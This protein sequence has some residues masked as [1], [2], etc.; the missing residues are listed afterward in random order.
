[1]SNKIRNGKTMSLWLE[2]L[3]NV[4]LGD[5][6]EAYRLLN[7]ELPL[8]LRV[9]EVKGRSEWRYTGPVPK[10]VRIFFASLPERDR[11]RAKSRSDDFIDYI[12]DL[13]MAKV[14][15]A[16][17]LAEFAREFQKLTIKEIAERFTGWNGLKLGDENRVKW[18][19][20]HLRSMAAAG[21]EIASVATV[22]ACAG[23]PNEGE[24]YGY[25]ELALVNKWRADLSWKD[26]K[27]QE[28]LDSSYV[29]ITDSGLEEDTNVSDEAFDYGAITAA[30]VVINLSATPSSELTVDLNRIGEKLTED[31]LLLLETFHADKPSD[32]YFPIAW[33]NVW[34]TLVS[35]YEALSL[36][37]SERDPCC[38]VDRTL[39]DY[40][41]KTYATVIKPSRLNIFRRRTRFQDRCV[42]QIQ[43]TLTSWSES[44]GDQGR[45]G[46]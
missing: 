10:L 15:R 46:S 29:S 37:L 16:V 14:G 40:I 27:A 34:W 33:H 26:F 36:D 30:R 2:I 38:D 5:S 21:I 17:S 24:N 12:T 43:S 41:S 45:A 11:G 35:S 19:H 4:S 6:A 1:M 18:V 44:G 42:E 9:P 22:E 8:A 20:K 32:G 7:F 39:A 3:K 25:H 13:V 23:Q 28:E 31:L